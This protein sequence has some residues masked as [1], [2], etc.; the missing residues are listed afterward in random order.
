MLV[1]IGTAIAALLMMLVE[2][3]QGVRTWPEVRGWWARV[4]AVDAIQVAVVFLFGLAVQPRIVAVQPFSAAALGDVG[5]AL[6]GYLALTFVFYWWHRWRHEVPF[7]WRTLHQV[8]H[9]PARIE[10]V[11][12]FYKHPLEILS[13]ASISATLLYVVLGLTPAQAAGAVLIAAVS[14]L[15]YHWN[16]ATP[17]WLGWFIQRP[18]MHCLHH[19]EGLH[20]FNYGDLPLWD[21]L[22]GTLR[23]PETWQGDCGFGDE[24]HRLPAMLAFQTVTDDVIPHTSSWRPALA[25][26][27]VALGSLG[28]IGDL[29]GTPWL[30]G[31]GLATGAAPAPK[32]FTS[33]DGLE[34][35]SSEFVLRFDDD[36]GAHEVTLTP[37]LY[38]RLEG[39]YNRRNPYGATFA[40]GP[41]LANQPATAPMLE[42]VGEWTFCRE[43]GALAELGLST[44][45]HHVDVTVV[46]LPWTHTELPLTLEVSCS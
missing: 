38:S 5:G 40:G 44:S 8:H 32:V 46:P 42:A 43:Q 15:F 17:Q 18:E 11:T 35:F 39:P 29:S 34:A 6:V 22:F 3:R 14:E 27:L 16:V 41:F 28:M 31:L 13:N 24:E 30:Y 21:W 9:S 19:E 1:P 7:L 37:A 36:D 20:A 25:V 33:R 10:V 12:S 23:N 4:L 45:V 26:G 2:Q